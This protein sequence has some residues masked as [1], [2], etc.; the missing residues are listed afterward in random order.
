MFLQVRSG[1]TVFKGSHRI[2]LS[3]WRSVFCEDELLYPTDRSNLL[4]LVPI[5]SCIWAYVLEGIER[6]KLV[7]SSII[8]FEEMLLTLFC[9]GHL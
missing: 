7:K 5:L 2:A 8:P 1:A 3:S 6:G 9:P 4:I